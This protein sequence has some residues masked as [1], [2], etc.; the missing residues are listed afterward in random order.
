MPAT[1]KT[2]KL[3]LTKQEIDD[4]NKTL[5]R[6]VLLYAAGV[7]RSLY[8]R[9]G[10][11]GHGYKL[12]S[13]NKLGLDE[14]RKLATEHSYTLPSF[15]FPYEGERTKASKNS[16]TG[17]LGVSPY[18]G[19]GRDI[20]GYSA[21]WREYD[22]KGKRVTRSKQFWCKDHGDNT[23]KVAAAFRRI[24]VDRDTKERLKKEVEKQAKQ[25]RQTP[26]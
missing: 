21:G 4:I 13:V 24:M 15:S 12:Y 22:K 9:V 14:A 23:L 19:D 5:P 26:E 17:I 10:T 2:P 1:Q 11:K 3:V 20:I 7:Y 18:R 6:R 25:A 16:E 8:F